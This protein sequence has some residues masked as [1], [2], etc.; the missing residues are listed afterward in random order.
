MITTRTFVRCLPVLAASVALTASVAAAQASIAGV[1]FDSLRTNAPLRGASVVLIELNRYATSDE[2][3]RFHFDSIVPGRYR[4]SFLHPVLDSLDVAAGEG[5]VD[6]IAGTATTVRLATPSPAS[7][8]ARVCPAPREK[9]TGVVL[10]RVRDVDD[11]A[12]VAGAVVSSA[13]VEL[14]VYNGSMMRQAAGHRATTDATGGFIFCGVPTD[15]PFTLRAALGAASAGPIEITLGATLVSRADLAVSR[16]PGT[17]ATRATVRGTVR[18]ADGRPLAGAVVA[19]AAADSLARADATG[20]FTLTGIAPGTRTIDVRALGLAPLRVVLDLRSGATVDTTLTLTQSAQP[21]GAMAITARTDQ[22]D[23]GGFDRRRRESAGHFLTPADITKHSPSEL[24][25]VFQGIPS[26]RVQTAGS[27]AGVP[28]RQLTMTSS[29]GMNAYCSPTIFLDGVEF[30]VGSLAELMDT[31]KP[32]QVKGIEVYRTGAP[33]PP[34]FDRSIR[35]GCG[36]VVVWT[37]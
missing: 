16:A 1:V 18:R 25:D 7:L 11:D 14:V 3:G 2:R 21:L 5:V 29:G 12:P 33:M 27:R 4:L 28:T 22:I 31:V 19:S 17:R 15:A 36:S 30:N 8:Y 32:D 35:T 34:R 9:A 23:G 6:A 26:L 20:G 13:W 37:R 10:G 24:A